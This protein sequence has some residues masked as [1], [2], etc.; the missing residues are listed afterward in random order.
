MVP[1]FGSKIT[2]STSD[3]RGNE[4]LLDLYT[5][6][7]SQ[8]NRKEGIA[9]MFKPEA[10]MSHIHGTPVSTDFMQERQRSVLTSKMN[11]TKPWEEIRVG[12]GF[13]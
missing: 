2:Q 12:P 10:N 5:G 13:K 11:N 7:G 1:Y 4:G 3:K 8:Q 6:S 9:P